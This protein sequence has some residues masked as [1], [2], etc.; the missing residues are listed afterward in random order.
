MNIKD[1]IY[2][3]YNESFNVLVENNKVTLITVDGCDISIM[4]DKQK[5]KVFILVPLLQAHTIICHNDHLSID[6][7]DVKSDNYWRENGNQVIE[8]QGAFYMHNIKEICDKLI[9]YKQ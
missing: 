4:L 6:G 7:F 3:R 1:L 2:V 5:D 8:Y 9:G